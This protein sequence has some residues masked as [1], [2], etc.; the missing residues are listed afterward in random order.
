MKKNYIKDLA[1]ILFI[2]FDRVI[3]RKP[4]ALT[5]LCYHSISSDN[6]IVDV[7]PKSFKDQINYL[8]KFYEFISADQAQK[9]LN[10]EIKLKKPS[11]LLTIDDGYK[12]V[13]DNLC[14]YLI[15]KNIPAIFFV[16]SNSE[17]VNRRELQNNKD[18]L[19]IKDVRKI[20]EMGFDIGSHTQ[21][22]SNL[23]EVSDQ[24]LAEEIISSKNKLQRDLNTKI[25]YF[26]YP[27][28]IF[29]KKSVKACREA[30]YRLAFTTEFG[31]ARNTVNKFLIPRIGVDS[32]YSM[33]GFKAIF[34]RSIIPYFKIK[35]IIIN[36]VTNFNKGGKFIKKMVLES[37]MKS[38]MLKQPSLINLLL[39]SFRKFLNN[40]KKES[41]SPCPNIIGPYK[42]V[43][44]I[45]KNNNYNNFGIGIYKDTGNKK[46]FIK[47]WQGKAKDFS[48]YSLV[49]E[50]N[51]T[52][53]LSETII[54]NNKSK[55][56][57][58]NPIGYLKTE[59]SLS[60][61]FE[62]I[63]G[64]PLSS[65]PISE[66]SIIINEA[67]LFINR[68]TP[69]LNKIDKKYIK[70]RGRLFYVIS[71]PILFLF[72]ILLERES[73]KTILYSLLKAYLHSL[74]I[75]NKRL[76][77][78]HG[79]LFPDNIFISN[80]FVYILDSEHM[81]HTFSEYDLNH[82]FII[83]KGTKLLLNILR[84]RKDFTQDTFLSL[85]IAIQSSMV[86]DPNTKQRH[87]FDYLKS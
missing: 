37:G 87:Y 76:T 7:T 43:S 13:L 48:Y 46:I 23:L 14:P 20:L 58:P 64:K 1:S 27:K 24:K 30:G 55:F 73:K 65:F 67:I 50:Y 12:D 38:D 60:I 45:K 84:N 17:L 59:N 22:H 36:E 3:F 5:V 25:S 21:T 82:L 6:T 83:K 29:S 33:L 66:Q 75:L 35:K 49:N 81:K 80:S 2:T 72:S 79:D 57:V 68:L 54:K 34:T 51:M 18:L 32:S 56:R 70:K 15:K 77:L 16:L 63:D 85:Y 10:G 11:I 9:Y 62:Y 8:S 41:K 78:V 31:V 52:K 44:K 69:K 74:S 26:A 61:I 40:K 47:A 86:R 42:L 71:L 53:I 19:G 28:G 4:R 39:C